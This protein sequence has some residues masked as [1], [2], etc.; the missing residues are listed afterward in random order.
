MKRGFISLITMS[1]YLIVDDRLDS[2]GKNSIASSETGRLR[3]ESRVKTS[4]VQMH[5]V[6]VCFPF[7]AKLQ[8]LLILF[9]FEMQ[10]TDK[11]A[12]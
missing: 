11:S 10:G 12:Q 9:P 3:V 8:D 2:N 7:L 4:N 1:S 5:W 6:D